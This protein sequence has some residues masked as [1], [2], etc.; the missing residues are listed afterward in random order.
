[1]DVKTM[2]RKMFCKIFG[3]KDIEVVT[4]VRQSIVGD[5]NIM[6]TQ[7]NSKNN[8]IYVNG[9]EVHID[10]KNRCSR[11]HEVIK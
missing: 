2:I 11:C 1:M 9:Q 8:R 6:I 5:G 3:H 4:E 7:T 10:P